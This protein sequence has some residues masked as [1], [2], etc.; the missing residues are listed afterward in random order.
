MIKAKGF[1]CSHCHTAG[2]VRRTYASAQSC[3]KHERVCYMNPANRACATCDH[4]AFEP[5]EGHAC[6][7]G[8]DIAPPGFGE[9]TPAGPKPVMHC[10]HWQAKESLCPA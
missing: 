4:W 10:P 1:R 2:R 3:A 8:H 5:G 6:S 7:E 9:G